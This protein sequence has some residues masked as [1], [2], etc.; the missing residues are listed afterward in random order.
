MKAILLWNNGLW[1]ELEVAE[2]PPTFMMPIPAAPPTSFK[3]F[4]GDGDD[5]SHGKVYDWVAFHR[6]A[7]GTPTGDFGVPGCVVYLQEAPK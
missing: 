4:D 3:E 6:I 1:E 5:L 7:L 2:Y